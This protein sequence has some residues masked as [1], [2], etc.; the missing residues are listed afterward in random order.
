MNTISLK[1]PLTINDKK[2]SSL[3]LR[4]PKV[5]DLVEVQNLNGASAQELH[6]IATLSDPALTHDQILELDMEDYGAIQAA[7][8]EVMKPFQNQVKGAARS[9]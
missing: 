3:V 4:R 6:L 9:N 7:L 8:A 5:K 2:V 1:Y